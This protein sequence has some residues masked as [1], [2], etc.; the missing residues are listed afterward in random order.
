[1]KNSY[2]F[3]VQDFLE[4]H[5]FPEFQFF[6]NFQNF[7]FLEFQEFCNFKNFAISRH[8]R[9]FVHKLKLKKNGHFIYLNTVN[10]KSKNFVAIGG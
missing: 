6:W 9:L 1:M 7:N 4:F 10:F 2:F 8:F 3:E 5:E